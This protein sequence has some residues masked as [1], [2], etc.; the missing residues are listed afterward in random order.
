MGMKKRKVYFS[1]K[2]VKFIIVIVLLGFIA[3][4]SYVFFYTNNNNAEK[5]NKIKSVNEPDFILSSRVSPLLKEKQ[6]QSKIL[7]SDNKLP[8]NSNCNSI[9][10]YKKGAK[11][12]KNDLKHLKL[13]LNEA[14]DAGYDKQLIKWIYQNYGINPSDVEPFKSTIKAQ[15]EAEIQWRNKNST[16]TNNLLKAFN[17]DDIKL[18]K[19]LWLELS[20]NTED[21]DHLRYFSTYLYEGIGQVSK[22]VI[23]HRLE[24]LTSIGAP[25]TPE[26]ILYSQAETLNEL[27]SFIHKHKINRF[28]LLEADNFSLLELAVLLK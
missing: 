10:P 27:E 18:A 15:I 21:K 9:N 2:N 14:L 5:H 25:I 4:L 24:F 20:H 6:K 12:E 17:Q 1:Q 26:V 8:A 13:K 23:D 16:A 22:D 11:L 28:D 3:Y 7:L 19:S